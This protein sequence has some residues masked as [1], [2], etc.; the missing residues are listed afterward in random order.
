M[1]SFEKL[2]LSKSTVKVLNDKGYKEPTEIQSKAIPILMEGEQDIIAQ[3]QT[4]TGKTLCFALPLIEKIKGG[5]EIKAIILSPT[6][7]LALQT[8]DEFNKLRGSNE[9]KVLTV[10]GGASISDQLNKLR[11]GVDIVVGTPGRVID[12]IDRGDLAINKI[13]YFVLDE[14]D[15]MLNMGF[16][17]DIEKILKQTPN[18]KRMLLFSATMPEPIKRIAKK[19]MKSQ[20]T[21][22]VRFNRSILL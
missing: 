6:R 4:G 15:E 1:E 20:V 22:H 11:R 7:E 9:L 12:L 18:N 5:K 19:F 13:Q 14:A 16:I 3:S 2:G 21:I 10:Y 17:G 8:T